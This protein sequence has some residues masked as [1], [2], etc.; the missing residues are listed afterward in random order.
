[1]PAFQ[2]VPSPV[3][4]LPIVVAIAAT[5]PTGPSPGATGPTGVSGPTGPNSTGP[6][7]STGPL[8]PSGSNSTATGPTGPIGLVGPPGNTVTGPTGQASTVTGPAGGIGN[9][10]PTGAAGTLTGPTGP[11]GTGPTGA[12]GSGGTG[13]IGPTGPSSGSTGPTGSTGATIFDIE[14]DIYEGGSVISTGLKGYLPIDFSGTILQATL[15]ADQT[16]SAV[17]DIWKCT[18]A[19]FDAGA[20]HPVDGDSICDNGSAT[21]PPTLS[22]AAKLKDNT[23][24]NWTTSISAGD[25]LAF[26][27]DSAT[28]ITHLTLALKVQR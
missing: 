6:T 1:M 16:G 15:L 4:A 9:T 28:T 25:I 8:G 12:T 11:I 5:G 10:G 3:A 21:T 17:V 18:Y 23:L 7:G 2:I 26:N 20:T 27:V 24:T 13:P 14:V 19:Q 22:S